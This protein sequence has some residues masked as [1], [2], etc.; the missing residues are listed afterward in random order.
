M[1]KVLN[2]TCNASGVVTAEG[3]EVPAAVVL[4][5]GKQDSTGV[6][7]LE[8]EKANYLTSNASDIKAL[9]ES[10]VDI[11][12]QIATI[13]TGLDAVTNSPG[14]QA[15]AIATLQTMKTELN[16]TKDLLK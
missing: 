1:S 16:L 14:A 4:S 9:I 13:A 3:Q 5:E 12:N 7:I 8:E 15:A 6:L 10:L 11:I 2:A